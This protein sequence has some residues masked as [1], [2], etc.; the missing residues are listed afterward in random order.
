LKKIKRIIAVFAAAALALSVF[1]ACAKKPAKMSETDHLFSQTDITLEGNYESVSDSK[2]IDGKFYLLAERTEV[3]LVPIGENGGAM[4]IRPLAVS[5]VAVGTSVDTG[6]IGYNGQV[7]PPGMTESYTNITSLLVVDETGKTL[8]SKDVN[9]NDYSNESSS[10]AW[11]NTMSVSP[12]GKLLAMKTT[13]KN[14]VD[15][16]G[17][18]NFDQKSQIVAFDESLNETVYFD[19]TEAMK[20]I[21]K[22]PANPDADTQVTADTFV[23]DE[24]GKIYLS[25]YMGVYVFDHQNFLFSIL[26]D[27]GASQNSYSYI[28]GIYNLGGFVAADVSESSGTGKDYKRSTN[29]KVIDTATRKYGN[30]YPFEESGSGS[31]FA[32]N[33]DYPIIVSDGA[34]LFSFNYE[35]GEKTLL[36]D[37]LASGLSIEY[38]SNFMILSPERFAIVTASGGMGRYYSSAMGGRATDENTPATKITIF[39]KIDPSTVKPRQVVT[40]YNYYRDNALLQF[41]SDF[42]KNSTEYEIDVKSYATGGYD[43]SGSAVTKLNNDIISGNIPDILLLSS[44]MP[45]DSYASKGLFYD[46]NKYIDADKDLTRDKLNADVLKTFTTNG[47][48]YSMARNFT[49]MGL[50]GKTS[51]FGDTRTLSADKLKEV[52]AAYPEAQIMGQWTQSDFINYMVG[53]QLSAFITKET[54]QVNFN[55]PE[56]IELLNIAKTYPKEYNNNDMDYSVY[57][58]MYRD[59]R[60]LLSMNYLQNFKDFYHTRYATFG[61][62]ITFMGFPNPNGSG[63]MVS[64]DTEMAIMTQGNRDAAWQV[65]KAYMLYKPEYSFGF[66]IF[67]DDIT[68][69]A[70]EAK[71]TPTYTD[72]VTGEVIEQPNTYYFANEEHQYPNNT[73]ADNQRIYDI[74]ADLGGVVRSDTELMKIIEEETAAFFAGSKT[75]EDCAKLIQNRATTYVAE[76]R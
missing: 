65:L 10:N 61:E 48:L 62:D 1:S 66:S 76:S 39:E 68:A 11:Y 36:I 33:K 63:I 54:G 67:T 45:Y 35:T 20:K 28:Q 24:T 73:D 49:V 22:D 74:L 60:A 40:I 32:G 58:T 5:T 69:L 26:N 27:N 37:F 29:L 64:A 8:A 3:K 30:S 51:I 9:T 38:Y 25:T 46:L 41:A 53:M 17:N 42:N 44:D 23:V 21:P 70:E 19:I 34:E 18:Y 59:D 52:M 12:D 7:V 56:F 16:D 47:K 75:A 31:V 2:Y 15:S 71:K 4:P 57:E 50:V 6:Y 72:P 13:T 14:S 43:P 55:S